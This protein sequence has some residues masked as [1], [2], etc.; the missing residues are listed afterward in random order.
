[1][2][3]QFLL[4]TLT[5]DIKTIILDNHQRTEAISKLQDIDLDDLSTRQLVKLVEHFNGEYICDDCEEKESTIDKLKETSYDMA[6]KVQ[7]L[8]LD[9]IPQLSNLEEDSDDPNNFKRSMKKLISQF[10]LNC[11]SV[12]RK[13]KEMEDL[14]SNFEDLTVVD[15]LDELPKIKE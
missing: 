13:F 3:K 7:T 6:E 8:V 9:M 12:Q 4:P 11:Q 2:T 5:P 1:M 10:K 14:Y 15:R